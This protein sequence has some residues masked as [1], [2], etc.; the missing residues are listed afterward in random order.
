MYISLHDVKLEEFDRLK[1]VM[2]KS[3]T[4]LREE[5]KPSYL[6][7]EIIIATATEGPFK[8]TLFSE[9]LSTPK[10]EAV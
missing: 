1:V 9:Y 3:Y 4:Q 10:T 8:L 7:G 6:V 5:N 2:S